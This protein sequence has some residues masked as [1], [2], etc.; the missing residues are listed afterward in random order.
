MRR[1]NACLSESMSATWPTV[2]SGTFSSSNG[3][4]V[5][6]PSP[7]C[8]AALAVTMLK[9]EPDAARPAPAWQYF[10]WPQDAAGQRLLGRELLGARR[11]ADLDL[12]RLGLL[13][14]RDAQL[15][16]AVGVAGL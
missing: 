9:R 15:E 14:D 10:R 2:K 4:T 11:G 5:S 1:R 6:L 12:A 16:H 7:R 13:A 3:S 8:L